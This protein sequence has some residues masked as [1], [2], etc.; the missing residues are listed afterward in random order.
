MARIAIPSLAHLPAETAHS[1]IREI[2]NEALRTQGA[3]HLQVGQP[4]FPTPQ[5]IKDAGK[6]AIDE[7]LSLIHI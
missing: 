6:R 1:G 5:H 2:G 4:N 3:I 7:N